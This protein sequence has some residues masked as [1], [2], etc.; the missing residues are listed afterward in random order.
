MGLVTDRVTIKSRKNNLIHAHAPSRKSAVR[1]IL[2]LQLNT[3]RP[4]KCNH[5]AVLEEFSKLNS[6]DT[7]SVKVWFNN[8]Q[9]SPRR[10]SDFGHSFYRL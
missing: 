5:G 2:V 1:V 10:I 9:Q 4:F 7:R 6:Q 3:G 8:K